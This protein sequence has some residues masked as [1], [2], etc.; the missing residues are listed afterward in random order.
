MEQFEFLLGEKRRIAPGT[1]EKDRGAASYH[2]GK[3]WTEAESDVIQS[4]EQSY[5]ETQ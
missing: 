1:R 4:D 2:F 3:V 5:E